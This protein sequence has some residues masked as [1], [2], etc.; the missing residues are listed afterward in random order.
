M[1][2]TELIFTMNA[3]LISPF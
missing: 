3:S 2:P 1:L